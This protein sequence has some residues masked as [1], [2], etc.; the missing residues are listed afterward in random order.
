MSDCHLDGQGSNPPRLWCSRLFAIAR[1]V[2]EQLYHSQ[3][4][5]VPQAVRLN[6]FLRHSPDTKRHGLIKGRLRP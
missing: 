6:V 3:Q 5:I 4:L 1:I 2:K